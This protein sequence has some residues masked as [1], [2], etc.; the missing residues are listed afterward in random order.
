MIKSH[1]NPN[2][3]DAQVFQHHLSAGQKQSS[4][5]AENKSGLF[6]FYLLVGLETIKNSLPESL[7]VTL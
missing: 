2:I 6:F 3:P 1:K 4:C 7:P 5:T